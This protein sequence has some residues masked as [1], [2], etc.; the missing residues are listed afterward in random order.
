M[1]QNCFG[2]FCSAAGIWSEIQHDPSILIEH[3][4][5]SACGYGEIN[6]K[7]QAGKVAEKL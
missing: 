6:K 7:T 4:L 1:E 5:K 2:F 3:P